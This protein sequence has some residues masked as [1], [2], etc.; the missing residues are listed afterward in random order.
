MPRN[1]F[2][3]FGGAF[4]QL[5]Q[6]SISGKESGVQAQIDVSTGQGESLL[7]NSGMYHSEH[8]ETYRPLCFCATSHGCCCPVNFHSVNLRISFWSSF[9]C[10]FISIF[11]RAF[12]LSIH[13]FT[14]EFIVIAE[15]CNV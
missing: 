3:R 7:G 13:S 5:V 15:G 14:C 12:L 6:R 4:H 11:V 1:Y 8:S 9:M 2:S 10:N